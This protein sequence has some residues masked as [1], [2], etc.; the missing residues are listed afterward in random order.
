MCSAI[1]LKRS[2]IRDQGVEMATHEHLTAA[3]GV[4]ISGMHSTITNI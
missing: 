1:T 4:V 2:L 3:T